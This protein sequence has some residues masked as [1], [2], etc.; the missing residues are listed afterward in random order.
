M[1][2]QKALHSLLQIEGVEIVEGHKMAISSEDEHL[3][4]EDVDRLPVSC[5]G[6]LPDD[7]TMSVVVDDLLV[8]LVLILLL[9]S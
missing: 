6:L 4:V 1:V 5:T 7:K 9:D 2:Q 8:H 3:I